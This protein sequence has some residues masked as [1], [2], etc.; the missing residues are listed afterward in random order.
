MPM[1]TKKKQQL[2]EQLQT[3]RLGDDSAKRVVVS[4]T[5]G[6]IEIRNPQIINNVLDYLMKE[7]RDNVAKEL[8]E[9]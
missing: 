1:E 7:L 3:I 2:I 4:A 5:S 9:C 6:E 8:T